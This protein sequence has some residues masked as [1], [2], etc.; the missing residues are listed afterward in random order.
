MQKAKRFFEFCAVLFALAITGYAQTPTPTP[1]QVEKVSTEEI[2]LNVLAFDA[3]DNFAANLQKE[4]LLI[5]EDGRLNQASSLRR[6][7]ANVLVVLDVGNQISYAK[8]NK[9][10]AETA[11]K[12][13]SSLQE[14]DSVAV[15]QYGDKV[16]IL[17]EWTRDKTQVSQNLTDRKLG[18]GRRSVFVEA[19]DTAVKFFNN[20]PL[21]N[22]HLILI[23]DGIDTFNDKNAKDSVTKKLLSSDI[24]VHVISYTR[25]Q[26]N[27]IEIPKSVQG[28]GSNRTP[29]LPPG[30]E[31]PHSKEMQKFPILT[32]NLDREMIRKRKE[33]M[34]SLKT[35]EVY[36]TTI[37]EDTNGEIFLPETTDEMIEKTSILAKNIDSQYVVTYIPKRPLNESTDG[38][39][40]QIEV[41]SRR[42]GV[43]VQGRRKFVVSNNK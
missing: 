29:P 23:T 16:D 30:A 24:N 41:S 9:T 11:R 19:M 33:E 31:A 2:K 36:L 37:A 6:I 34:N 22:R 4:D 39:V 27:A 10:T 32:I 18:F 35:S 25:L 43:Q 14:N 7:P 13:I 1:E 38:E 28:G 3:S 40:H 26:Q 8:R 20:T 12:L 15:M 42:A 17:S 5:I 21:E